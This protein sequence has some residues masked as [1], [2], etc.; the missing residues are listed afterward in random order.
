MIVS[1][2]LSMGKN[3]GKKGRYHGW[4]RCRQPNQDEEAD[5]IFYK[6]LGK[7]LTITNFV[8]MRELN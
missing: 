8:L 1:I 2:A 6:L 3:K 4:E 5:E 7:N